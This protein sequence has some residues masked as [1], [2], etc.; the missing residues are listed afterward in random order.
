M[1]LPWPENKLKLGRQ[2]ERG[3]EEGERL[4]GEQGEGADRCRAGHGD[5]AKGKGVGGGEGCTSHQGKPLHGRG[6]GRARKS[7]TCGIQGKAS[8]CTRL[9]V[10]NK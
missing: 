8:L 6:Q 7:R 4:K 5:P 9:L 2:L 10:M 3:G 1:H